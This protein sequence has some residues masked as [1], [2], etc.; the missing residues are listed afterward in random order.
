MSASIIW[1]YQALLDE[2]IRLIEQYSSD[3]WTDYN[4]HDPGITTL[5]FLCYTLTDLAGRVGLPLNSHLAEKVGQRIRLRDD[6]AQAHEILPCGG[7]TINDLRKLLIDIPGIRNAWLYKVPV[8]PQP[9]ITPVHPPIFKIVNK[10][11]L[12]FDGD[13]EDSLRIRGMYTVEIEYEK[14]VV[15][16]QKGQLK[17]EVWWTLMAN[18]NLC[19]DVCRVDEVGLEEVSV[20]IDVELALESNVDEVKAEMLYVLD[21][22]IAPRLRRY[23]LNEMM[24]LGFGIEEI[25]N[26]P[27]GQNGFILNQDLQSSNNREELHGSDLVQLL[28]DIPQL[29]TIRR[30][31]FTTYQ[32]GKVIEIDKTAIVKLAKNRASRFS[33][34]KSRFRFFKE[35]IPY[36][37]NPAGVE[38]FLSRIR[39]RHQQTPIEEADLRVDLPKPAYVEIDNYTS[40]QHH[41]PANYGVGLEGVPPQALV[42]RKAAV[43]QFKAFLLLFEQFLADFTAQI[44][45]AVHLLSPLPVQ[46]SYA[47]LLPKDVPRFA[48]LVSDESDIANYYE[49]EEKF[50]I[51]RN[52]FLDHLLARYGEQYR[53][54]SMLVETVYEAGALELL[55]GDKQRLLIN[56]PALSYGRF[57]AYE[58]SCKDEGRIISGLE[59]RLRI[60]LGYTSDIDISVLQEKHFEI[61]EELDDDGIEEFRFRIFDDTRKI[62]LSSTRRILSREETRLEM[63]SALLMGTEASNY[64]VSETIDGQWHYTLFD[65]SGEMIGRRIQYFPSAELCR[66]ARDECVTF[67]RALFPENEIF[68]LE[69]MLLRPPLFDKESNRENYVVENDDMYLLPTC[70]DEDDS[71]CCG[72]DPYSFR[73]SV[74]MPAWPARFQDM[75]FRNFLSRFIREQ[76]PAHIFAK[77]CWL[78]LEQMN[79]FR[80]AFDDWTDKLANRDILPEPSVYLGALERLIAV[81]RQLRSVYPQVHLYDCTDVKDITPT[82]LGDTALGEMKGA[83]HD[84]D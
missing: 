38:Q 44:G 77:V 60:L 1:N 12:S 24:D 4:V 83:D 35:G 72:G 40:I 20:C 73:I 52:G 33:Q 42:Q 48:E 34:E 26:G 70:F 36:I 15:A 39:S 17:K 41:Y 29:L 6:F 18:R 64:T 68:V 71:D 61:Y 84:Q 9:P 3:S 81:W 67:L 65:K 32:N 66:A 7:V 59:R 22:F 57:Q 53:E 58:Y 19:E 30:L 8:E 74:I 10:D 78:S 79:Q 5:E 75:N 2:G 37:A 51:R 47:H 46:R 16:Q 27:L 45:H 13:P 21:E 23:T 62:L 63:R 54:Y 69:H 49:N 28:M 80:D 76:T 50:S 31:L 82:V 14:T 11:R 43:K 55:I 56:F 25:F